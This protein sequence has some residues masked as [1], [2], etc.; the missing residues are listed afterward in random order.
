MSPDQLDALDAA[1]ST[2]LTKKQF[3][4]CG[5][6]AGAIGGTL[7]TPMDVAKTRIMLAEVGSLCVC[8]CVPVVPKSTY[9]LI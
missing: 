5:T 4:L 3:A 1:G 9:A 7:T 8:V 6:V 2:S